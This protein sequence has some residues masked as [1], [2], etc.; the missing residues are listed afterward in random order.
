MRLLAFVA[1]FAFCCSLTH[2]ESRSI[3][4]RITWGDAKPGHKEGGVNIRVS[5]FSEVKEENKRDISVEEAAKILAKAEGWGSMVRVGIVTEARL[6]D[7]LPI[8][9]AIAKNGWLDLDFID[10]GA[11]WVPPDK[12][13]AMF[14]ENSASK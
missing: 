2:A 13:G 1:F 4:V 11:G 7:Y 6:V 8:V 3:G 14:R 12:Y 5:I 10:G 9:E